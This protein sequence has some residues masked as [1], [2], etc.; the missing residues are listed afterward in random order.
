MVDAVH[1]SG[2]T[3]GDRIVDGGSA[4][5][6][7]L[8]FPNDFTLYHAG[9]TDVFESMKLIGSRFN[10]DVA[11]LPIGG[12]FTMDP[13]G[14]SEAIRLLSVTSVIPIHYGTFPA[15]AGTPEELREAAGDV[16]DLRV[17]ALKPGETVGQT[18][19]V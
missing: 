17:V 1:S 18:D 4:A 8:R 9:D 5:G 6:F 13:V 14:A 12:H 15:L 3:D 2:I 7:V 10:P 11:M 16:S 19:L